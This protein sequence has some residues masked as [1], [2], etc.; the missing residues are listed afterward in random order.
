[1]CSTFNNF[2]TFY[3]Y[4]LKFK[5]LL[6]ILKIQNLVVLVC[7]HFNF[8]DRKMTSQNFNLKFY[9]FFVHLFGSDDRMPLTNTKPKNH[10]N[11][12]FRSRNTIVTMSNLFTKNRIMQIS[13]H[14]ISGLNQD[15]D[16]LFSVLSLFQDRLSAADI[17]SLTIHILKFHFI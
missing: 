9:F 12:L 7:Q 17:K 5:T 11:I 16:E 4:K 2:L 8:P 10:Q 6:D 1:M 13:L 3:P 15:I 14:Y